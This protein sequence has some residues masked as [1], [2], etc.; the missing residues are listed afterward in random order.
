MKERL[1]I[2]EH[3]LSIVGGKGRNNRRQAEQTGIYS[4]II[5]GKI[6]IL[7]LSLAKYQAT[8][9]CTH[10]VCNRNV[11]SEKATTFLIWTIPLFSDHY[12]TTVSSP[13][14]NPLYHLA[15]NLMFPELNH[16]AVPALHNNLTVHFTSM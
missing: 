8:D 16:A 3:N 5:G 7:C 9:D 2:G 15:T 6:G 12:L 1:A 11:K 14:C 4:I 13:F 10:N